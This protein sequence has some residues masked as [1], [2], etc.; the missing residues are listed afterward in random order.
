MITKCCYQGCKQAPTLRCACYECQRI[1]SV[2]KACPEHREFVC[3]YMDVPTEETL[4]E[5]LK[6]D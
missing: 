5:Q 3:A 6:E 1:G 4:V 2:L